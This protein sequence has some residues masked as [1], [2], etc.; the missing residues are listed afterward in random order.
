MSL[1]INNTQ[2]TTALTTACGGATILVR[3]V[4]PAPLV[5]GSRQNHANTS[6]RRDMAEAEFTS[7]YD[8]R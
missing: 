3:K 4:C 5:L 7:Y 1:H 6:G 8:F 2:P